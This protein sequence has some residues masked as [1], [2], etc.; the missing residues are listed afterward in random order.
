MRSARLFVVVAVAILTLTMSAATTSASTTLHTLHLTKDCAT[1]TG[2]APTYCVIAASNLRALPVRAKVWYLGPVLNNAYFLSSNIKIDAWHGNTA[3]GY[4]QADAQTST[5][6]CTFW[7]GTGTLT[8]FHAVLK[9][10]IDA[11][12]LW[13]WDGSYYFAGKP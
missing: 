9:V 3:T 12:G 11:K 5:G 1:N 13:H 7:K 2:I 10:S 8:G 6:L 4:C